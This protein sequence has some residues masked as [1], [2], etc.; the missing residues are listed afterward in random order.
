MTS[1]KDPRMKPENHK[2]LKNSNATAIPTPFSMNTTLYNGKT[3]VASVLLE[4][5]QTC[6]HEAK[7]K[8]L[9]RAASE[10]N[11]DEIKIK[12]TLPLKSL[13]LV[14]D[15]R[16]ISFMSIMP[17]DNI[18][19]VSK[20]KSFYQ[21]NELAGVVQHPTLPQALVILVEADLQKLTNLT[22]D[23]ID[24]GPYKQLCVLF[25]EDLAPKPKFTLEVVQYDL[26]T[27]HDDVNSPYAW[28][29]VAQYLKF[30]EKVC[31]KNRNYFVCTDSWF[32]LKL[33]KMTYNTKFMVYGNSDTANM[34]I[35]ANQ[36]L[37][38]LQTIT[39]PLYVMMVSLLE[40]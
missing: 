38:P 16:P 1:S 18:V 21:V 25:I 4:G 14:L 8:E 37:K 34:L 5:K 29:R 6:Y 22:R 30:P 33:F 32:F 13:N 35:K 31:H 3:Y 24:I 17:K 26:D 20:L 11:K 23:A 19:P 2:R 39:T 36:E 27:L 7:I 40:L 10:N 28:K 9:I 12:Y 15:G